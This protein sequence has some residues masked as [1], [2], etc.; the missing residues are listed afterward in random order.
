MKSKLKQ[1]SQSGL[2][3]FFILVLSLTSVSSAN[4]TT[5]FE[6][7]LD[8]E[9][10]DNGFLVQA[11]DRDV[12]VLPAPNA[13]PTGDGKVLVTWHGHESGNCQDYDLNSSS[14]APICVTLFQIFDED[15]NSLT[16][17][18]RVSNV[19]SPYYFGAPDATWNPDRREWVLHWTT[20]S[21][22]VP[23][24][25][26]GIYLQ[27]ISESGQLVGSVVALTTKV[28][29]PNLT[30]DP[31]T[32]GD[33]REFEINAK[34][35][36]N[37]SL[38]YV[39]SLDQWLFMVSGIK[40]GTGEWVGAYQV[41]DSQLGS[42]GLPVLFAQT[43]DRPY[44]IFA[45]YNSS[46]SEV[47]AI[48]RN[49]GM[50]S[51]NGFSANV[52]DF[53]GAQLSV[54]APFIVLT[55][56]DIVENSTVVQEGITNLHL[57]S[58]AIAYVSSEDKYVI[59]FVQRIPL[60][61]GSVDHL[62]VR[63]LSFNASTPV[64]GEPILVYENPL[65]WNLSPYAQRSW[66]N[67]NALSDS[68]FISQTYGATFFR[69]QY[70]NQLISVVHELN[71]D[72]LLAKAPAFRVGEIE[73]ASR[74][75][76]EFADFYR[77]A[78]RP[79]MQTTGNSTVLAFMSYV[80]QGWG[81]E[82]SVRFAVVKGGGLAP[83]ASGPSYTGPLVT[84]LVSRISSGSKTKVEGS[85]FDSISSVK[86][87]GKNVV[88]KVLSDQSLEIEIPSDLGAGKYD[89][90]IVSSFGTLT[91]QEKLEVSTLQAKGPAAIKRLEGNRVRIAH[92]SPVGIG[93]L[94]FLLN[95][96]VI[97]SI[98]TRD[99]NNPRLRDGTFVRTVDLRSGRNVVQIKVAGKVT[100]TVT[101]TR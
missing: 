74:N 19:G 53:S 72:D 100:R 2:T 43:R 48:Y 10:S 99:V 84:N 97:A 42:T 7:E 5:N 60:N 56:N 80:D 8:F 11:L 20:Y 23:V 33:D 46:D 57:V 82:P 3:L 54:S 36:A 41:F 98:N 13:S 45:A 94:E 68:I 14:T 59:S 17:I 95:G 55:Q 96:R 44:G 88:Y 69:S 89:L 34:N 40:A 35:S 24:G 93:K 27:R 16:P 70:F 26:A 39:D 30:N 58:P 81:Q 61:P 86:L 63:E 12:E 52:F 29:D 21:G 51:N 31:N 91:L 83:V 32:P 50:N 28:I 73:P 75:N 78:Q 47:V 38:T 87:G 79:A 85:G 66:M 15:G 37:T 1:L 77:P 62:Y 65:P 71:P 4:A 18:A 101:Y 92:L 49:R 22:T 90:V 25:D 9:P 6:Q 76:G 67:Y 64:L